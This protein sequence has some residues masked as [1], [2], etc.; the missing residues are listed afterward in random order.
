MVEST[1]KECGRLATP[2]RD[3]EALS[4]IM[5][6]LTKLRYKARDALPQFPP[7]GDQSAWYLLTLGEPSEV[8]YAQTIW[9]DKD[10][11]IRIESMELGTT[12][13]WIIGD[14]GEEGAVAAT[15]LDY[16]DLQSTRK[17]LAE[18]FPREARRLDAYQEILDD[19]SAK[20]GIHLELRCEGGKVAAA[21]Y[22]G[23]TVETKDPDE[24][25]KTERIKRNLK[26][27]KEAW[28][29]MGEYEAEQRKRTTY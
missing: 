3:P 6:K 18:N 14:Y 23:A 17:I 19:I 9:M 16:P 21:F 29:R 7:P 28:K 22:M 8:A 13:Q 15:K 24:E 5:A 4:Q 10:N 1:S 2:I 11:R 27:L 26:G 25:E 20:Y 12:T